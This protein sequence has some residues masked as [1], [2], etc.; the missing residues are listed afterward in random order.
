MTMESP[1]ASPPLF[2]LFWEEHRQKVLLALG[3]VLFL[4]LAIGGLLLLRRSHRLASEELLSKS[5]T[6]EDWQKVITSY[7]SSGA[8]ADAML[9]K[10][11]AQ[12]QAHDLPASNNTYAQFLEKFPH[13]PLAV[14]AMIGRALN[15]DLI[16]HSDQA[17]NELQQASV[18]YPQSY[19][20]PFALWMRARLL[21]RLGKMEDS[22]KTLQMIST[23]YPDS[24]VNNMLLHQRIGR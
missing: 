22:K 21:T 17:L 16:G 7:P 12:R 9:L 4:L 14:S 20:A 8:A 13:H 6:I 10:A 1:L 3:V 15:D 24:F 19:G 18:A 11:A 2:D 5:T 23:Q